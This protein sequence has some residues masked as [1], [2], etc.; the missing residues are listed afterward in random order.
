[1]TKVN[2]TSISKATGEVDEAE[3]IELADAR[4]AG[5]GTPAW[6]VAVSIVTLTLTADAC[7]TSACTKSC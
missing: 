4:Q 1:M 2:S 3:L 6:S 5:G 7:P